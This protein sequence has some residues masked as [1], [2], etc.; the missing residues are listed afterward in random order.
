MQPNFSSDTVDY[1][2]RLDAGYC[3]MNNPF[4]MLIDEIG[5]VPGNDLVFGSDGMPHGIET[6]IQQSLRPSL[7]QQKLSIDEFVAGYCMNPE[8]SGSIQLTIEN[9]RVGK[10]LIAPN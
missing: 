2:D 8:Q 9:D 10:I 3:E 6:A 7:S 1:R 5:F 4:R